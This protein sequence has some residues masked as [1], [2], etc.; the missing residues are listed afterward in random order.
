MRALTFHQFGDPSVLK[1]EERPTPAATA[2]TAVIQVKAASINPSDVKNV[3]GAMEGTVLPRVPG[4]DYSGVVVDGPKEWIGA[5]VWGSG[6]DIGFTRDGSHASHLVVPAAAL[7]RKPANLTHEQAAAIGVNF[8]VAW[9]GA[10]TYGQI[11]S[12]ETIVIVGAGGGV[13]GAVAQIAKA[14]GLRIIGAD[15]RPVPPDAPAAKRLDAVIDSLRADWP[16]EVVRLTQ[17]KGADIVYDTV[18]GVMFEPSLQTLGRR[19][20]QIMIS[21]TGKRRVEFDALHFYHQELQLF[22]ADSRKLDVAA[23]AR[24]LDELAPGFEHG[25]YDPP[26]IAATY[27]LEK[28]QEAYAAVAKGTHGRVVLVP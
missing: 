20:R 23:S 3:Q 7:A 14:K 5:E 1:L 15:V 18:G 12:G 11:Q 8:I 13:G 22:G 25:D 28:A 24:M 27:P 4:R 26:L 17:G 19:G 21:A 2:D 16:Q 6:G 10:V 9:M